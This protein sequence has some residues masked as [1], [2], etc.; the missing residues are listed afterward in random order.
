MLFVCS[1][2]SPSP[3]IKCPRVYLNEVL[4]M[5]SNRVEVTKYTDQ[6]LRAKTGMD[7]I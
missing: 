2:K 6:L 1:D 3:K 4:I 7:L 5:K